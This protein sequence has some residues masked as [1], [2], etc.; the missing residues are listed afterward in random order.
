MVA[1]DVRIIRALY[2]RRARNLEL[3]TALTPT[4][5]FEGGIAHF[6]N[7]QEPLWCGAP[8]VLALREKQE[9]YELTDTYQVTHVGDD[10]LYLVARAA[11]HL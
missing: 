7:E 2:E 8:V 4:Q 5:L 9:L 10:Q 11:D 6:Q 1:G 3:V